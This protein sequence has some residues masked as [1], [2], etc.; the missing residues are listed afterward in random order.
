MK[1]ESAIEVLSEIL[2]SREEVVA[3]IS[4]MLVSGCDFTQKQRDRISEE[5]ER[6]V[7]DQKAGEKGG[8]R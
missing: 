8:S 6:N 1:I 3:V 7:R 2:G 4:E 5:M